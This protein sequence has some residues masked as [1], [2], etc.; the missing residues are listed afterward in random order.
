MNKSQYDFA[1]QRQR[2][3]GQLIRR[4]W[5]LQCNPLFPF[6]HLTKFSYRVLSAVRG[7]WLVSCYN[8][9]LQKV[10]IRRRRNEPPTRDIRSSYRSEREQRS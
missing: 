10:E 5:Y 2:L 8:W 3:T 4:E 6:E 1:Y 7:R 9:R